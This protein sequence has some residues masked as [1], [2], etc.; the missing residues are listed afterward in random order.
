MCVGSGN[1]CSTGIRVPTKRA[2][3]ITTHLTVDASAQ[4][5]EITLSSRMLCVLCL[6]VLWVFS[7]VTSYSGVKVFTQSSRASAG[8]TEYSM[9]YYGYSLHSCSLGCNAASGLEVYMSAGTCW[10]LRYKSKCPAHE[11]LH[12][13]QCT[14]SHQPANDNESE[15]FNEDR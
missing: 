2:P 11:F 4:R 13:Y 6:I 9:R 14:H 7:L 10:P 8:A 5:R 3:R 1:S 15:E 12:R